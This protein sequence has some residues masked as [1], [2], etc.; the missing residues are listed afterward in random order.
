MARIVLSHLKS[1]NRIKLNFARPIRAI[2]DL[3]ARRE[4]RS[5]EERAG[6]CCGR[7]NHF[8]HRQG[9]R[10]GQIGMEGKGDNAIA[11]GR[12]CRD[13]AKIGFAFPISGDIAG[14]IGVKVDIELFARGRVESSLNRF[15]ASGN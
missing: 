10:V 9:R 14:V 7:G 11:I 8:V 2:H 4:L 12:T 6:S 13:R 1:L 5:I 15:G 3:D